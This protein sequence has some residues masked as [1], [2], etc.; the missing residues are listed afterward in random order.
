MCSGISS[1][2]LPLRCDAVIQTTAL[3]LSVRDNQA[4]ICKIVRV[5]TRL[6]I[7]GPAIHSVLL[8]RGLANRGYKSLLVAG[9]CEADDGDMSYLLTADDDV[10]WIPEMSRSV[11]PWKNLRALWKLWRLMRRERPMIVHT[12]TAMAG[13]LG[14][15]AAILSGVPIIV[16]T[17]HGNSLAQ[18]FSPVI[19]AIF[20]NIERLL[21][22]RTDAICV[23]SEQQAEE[24]S[25]KF[26]IAPRRKF[27]MVPLGLELQPF[28]SLPEP[29]LIGPLNVAWLGRLVPV[30]NIPLLVE[31]IETVLRRTS[32]V[33][34]VIAG[35]GP[36]RVAVQA[37]CARHPEQVAWVGWQKDVTALIAR[38]D[39]LIQTSHNE[40]TPVALIQGMA[41]NRPF[42]ATPA[43]GVVN[44]VSGKVSEG[45]GGCRWFEQG[46]LAPASAVAFA[47]ALM[48]LAEDRAL[49]LR[50]GSR[51]RIYAAQRYGLE[52]LLDNI[53]SIYAKLLH[54]AK[55]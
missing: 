11:R 50:M 4:S 47:G 7:G 25:E 41:A 23:V 19:S 48:R 40:G 55:P 28:L 20:R 46:V 1:L 43:G 16:H 51:A 37:V 53:G 38:C 35:D 14:R 30:K 15:T 33:K 6:N 21:A 49:L 52:T 39:V 26:Q 18:Y 27:H 24:L 3:R 54:E 13:S 42:I 12:H 32:G 9:S 31:I 45:E 36:D 17:F 29:E 22:L 10:H 5:I 8:T 44:M 2:A 34:F